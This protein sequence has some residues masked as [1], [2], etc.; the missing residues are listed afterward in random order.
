MQDAHLSVVVGPGGAA[1]PIYPV[2]ALLLPP[3]FEPPGVSAD[4]AI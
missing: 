2:E 1:D 3:S 4:G